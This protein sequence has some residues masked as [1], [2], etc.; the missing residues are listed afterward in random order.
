MRGKPTRARGLT[1][2]DVRPQHF[3]TRCLALL[4]LACASVSAVWAAPRW[5]PEQAE[6]GAAAS[7]PSPKTAALFESAARTDDGR[8]QLLVELRQPAG[9]AAFAQAM[10]AAAPSS[11]KRRITSFAGEA[12]VAPSPRPAPSKRRSLRSLTASR[13]SRALP[14]GARP[15][16]HRHRDRAGTSEGAAAPPR[17]RPRAADRSRVPDELD[18][19]ALPGHARGLGEHPGRRFPSPPTA[20]GSPSASS[21][22]APTTCIRLRRPRPR[23]GGP[24]GLAT[25]GRLDGDANFP[26][27]LP[28][29]E[30]GGRRRLRGEPTPAPMPR[31]PTRT[32]WTATATAPTSRAPPRVRR[33]ADAHLHRPWD[34]T[35]DFPA[36]RIGTGTAPKPRSTPCAS[37][38][39]SARPASPRWPSTGRWTPTT[40][41]TSP[42]TSTSSTCRSAATGGVT[43]PPWPPTMRRSSASSS[44]PRPATPATP[45]SSPARR[46]GVAR[47][48]HRGFGGQRRLRR[49]RAGQLAAL[50]RRQLPR[51]RRPVRPGAE[52][53]DRGTE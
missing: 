22:P 5:Q 1:M 17:R 34:D 53:A 20:T 31:S 21:T 3:S 48:R 36:M 4:A 46:I 7:L 37:S 45:T 35:A 29:R 9:A 50:G 2:F 39:A 38:A 12:R 16:R 10:K 8:V 14:R 15:R 11:D 49:L 41:T 43:P 52:R 26:R 32:R 33:H 30:G 47:R 23:G 6:E 24:D 19:R 18:D 28:D 13:R 42:T 44:S 27:Q 25:T 51:R 40:T